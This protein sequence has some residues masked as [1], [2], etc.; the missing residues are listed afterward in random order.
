MSSDG[1]PPIQLPP[2]DLAPVTLTQPAPP[3]AIVT[4]GG[5]GG[6]SQ[7]VGLGAAPADTPLVLVKGDDGLLRPRTADYA[8]ANHTHPEPWGTRVRVATTDPTDQAPV[9][10]VHLN[11]LT[12]RI[13]RNEG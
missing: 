4:P 6:A 3:T 13:F 9:G 8:P 1:P 5:G 7:I 12:G 2:Q 11:A 10:A